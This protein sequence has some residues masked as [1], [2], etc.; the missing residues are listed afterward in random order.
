MEK[1]IL[2]K[3]PVNGRP[4]KLG[5]VNVVNGK[6]VRYIGD[7]QLSGRRMYLEFN[8]FSEAISNCQEKQ[9]FEVKVEELKSPVSVRIAMK[10]FR[11]L[12]DKAEKSMKEELLKGYL[13]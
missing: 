7:D 2:S 13:S 10:L 8:D 6:L 4:K 12:M 11:P 9:K 1:V 3:L 5:S